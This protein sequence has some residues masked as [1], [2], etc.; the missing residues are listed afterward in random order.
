MCT[1]PFANDTTSTPL[2]RA[3]TAHTLLDASA[4]CHQETH[5]MEPP[6]AA[7]S[8]SPILPD[9]RAPSTTETPPLSA[10]E[11]TAGGDIET[12]PAS[13][14]LADFGRLVEH[15]PD[16]VDTWLRDHAPLDV[17][18]RLCSVTSELRP[19]LP[20]A[21]GV[22]S[23]KRAA[24]VTSE[25]FQ[26]WLSSSAAASPMMVSELMLHCSVRG[27]LKWCLKMAK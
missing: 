22:A 10:T 18:R 24:S 14:L 19:T 12:P 5:I 20:P 9:H 17:V 15:D 25:L 11:T 7:S 4:A 27:V 1:H 13:R 23:P 2:S 8:P 21:C 6:S 26:Q 3:L 16:A